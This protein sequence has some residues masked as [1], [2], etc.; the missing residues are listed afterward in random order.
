MYSYLAV[1]ELR[2]G[3]I[4]VAVIRP[5]D[6]VLIDP[7]LEIAVAAREPMYVALPLR[8]PLG[9]HKSIPLEALEG[10]PFVGFTPQG[11][12]YFHVKII[13]PFAQHRVRPKLSI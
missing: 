8:H 2:M 13:G 1:E 11:R 3:R 9:R 6:A 7:S 5:T 4:D 12:R 10:V